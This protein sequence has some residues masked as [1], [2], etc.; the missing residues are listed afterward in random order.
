MNEEIMG[1]RRCCIWPM[2]PPNRWRPVAFR[3]GGV[4]ECGLLLV[5]ALE[6]GADFLFLSAVK[7][8]FLKKF[9]GSVKCV[10]KSTRIL[11]AQHFNFYK[12][13]SCI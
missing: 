12:L 9:Y 6:W 7:V 1:G 3:A 13:N 4:Q 11:R 2:S 8:E 5:H 10:G